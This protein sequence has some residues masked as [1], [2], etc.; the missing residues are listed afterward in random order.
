MLSRISYLCWMFMLSR[1]S[2]LIFLYPGGWYSARA[3]GPKYQEPLWSW[4]AGFASKLRCKS[5]FNS[6][7]IRDALGHHRSWSTL[8]QVKVWCHFGVKPL[9][10]QYWLFIKGVLW[11]SSECDFTRSAHEFNPQ[12]VFG[13]Y[14]FIIT[15]TSPRGQWGNVFHSIVLHILS[16]LP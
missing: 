16:H 11:H 10:E 1:I 14:N 12:H 8:V 5:A 4:G 9:S 13:D 6:M 15:T 3:E 7:W 2:Y